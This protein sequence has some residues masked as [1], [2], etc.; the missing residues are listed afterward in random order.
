MVKLIL[1]PILVAKRST[2][3]LIRKSIKSS[4]LALGTYNQNITTRSG[5]P[6]K[7]VQLPM[8]IQFVG[9][10]IV[11]AEFVVPN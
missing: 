8:F 5:D 4:V 9:P 2:R 10:L 11:S 1:A 3:V 6:G 7:R